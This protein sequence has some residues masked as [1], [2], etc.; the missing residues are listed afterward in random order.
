MTRS[1][2]VLPDPEGPSSA[3]SSPG[4][5]SS[6][7]PRSAAPASKALTRSRTAMPTPAR[8][9]LRSTI[10]SVPP[11]A[12]EGVGVTP[13]E[14]GLERQGDES[15]EGEERSD[16]EGGGKIVFIVEDLDM[17]GQRVG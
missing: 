8:A 15:Q 1:S 9:G 7:T 5:T 10:A 14:E 6:D 12:G 16:R 3:K 17:Q 13:L 11:R 2:V 4:A